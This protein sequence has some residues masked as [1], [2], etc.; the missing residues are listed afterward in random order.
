MKK[1]R[2]ACASPGFSH[3]A[4]IEVVSDPLLQI[5]YEFLI[6]VR[7]N[8]CQVV[9]LLYLAAENTLILP[10]SLL[11]HT[12]SEATPYF[13]PLLGGRAAAVLQGTNLEHIGIVPAF[14]QSRVGK[15]KPYRIVK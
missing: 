1:S 13:L 5:F 12:Q 6:T 15:N 10:V 7:G 9:Y 14:P 8:D 3:Y 11:I 4:A 2:S